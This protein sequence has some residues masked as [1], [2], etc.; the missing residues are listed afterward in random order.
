MTLKFIA[1]AAV[2]SLAL[3]TAASANSFFELGDNLER[4]T[5]LD[6]GLV[7]SAEGAGTLSI[8]DYHR[9][10]QGKL[11]GTQSVNAG[12]NYKTRVNVGTRPINDVIAVLTVNGQVVASRDYD[13]DRN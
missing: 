4:R 13:I 8:Y 5:T 12:P 3:A 6:L 10:E 1:L 11:L 9:G 7:V 2:T